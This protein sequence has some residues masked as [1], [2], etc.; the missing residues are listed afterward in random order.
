MWVQSLGWEDPLREGTATHS[1]IVNADLAFP[2][3]IYWSTVEHTQLH[4]TSISDKAT[5]GL[6]YQHKIKTT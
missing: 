1:S 4:K 2:A 6:E 3:R 5:L